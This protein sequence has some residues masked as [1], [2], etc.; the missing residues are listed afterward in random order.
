MSQL[1][2]ATH[3]LSRRSLLTSAGAL[4]LSAVA[5]PGCSEKH[6]SEPA[7]QP[8]GGAPRRGG[9]LTFA[10]NV[11]T[12]N[13][14]LDP[15]LASGPSGYLRNVSVFDTLTATNADGWR[16][17]PRL[18][19]LWEP[20]ADLTQWHF[21]LRPGVTFHDGRPLEAKDVVWT[22]RRI[23]DKELGSGRFSRFARTMT[24][25]GLSAPDKSTVV[26]KLTRPDSQLPYAFADPETVIVRDGQANFDPASYFGTGPYKLVSWTPGESLEMERNPDYWAGELPYLDGIRRVD[27][28]EAATATQGVLSGNYD[29]AE[30][31]SYA[32]AAQ[33]GQSPNAQLIRLPATTSL[34]L[35]MDTT[36]P[37]FTDPNV[38]KA[39]KL[40]V[41]RQAVLNT[42]YA[43]FGAMTGDLMLAPDDVYYPDGLGTGTYDPDQAKSLL[44]T[45]GFP[46]GLDIDLQAY[47]TY[48]PLAVAFADTAKAAGIRVKVQQGNP[49][50]YWDV[51]YL[52]EKFYTSDWQQFFPPDLLWYCYGSDATYN[53]SK[54]KIPRIDE[55][56][57]KILATTDTTQQKAFVKEGLGLAAQ[58]MGHIIP[59]MA[60]QLL[61]AKKNVQGVASAPANRYDL[62]RVYLSA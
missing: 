2:V 46:D 5:L 43:G 54:L 8:A 15:Q 48:S 41:D 36:Q 56:Y 30:A 53:E 55:L 32:A 47:G 29:I 7:S 14:K 12:V 35:V 4:A 50:T 37:P 62:R 10:A 13:E 33:L 23:L 31:V 19:E 45:A 39:F 25:D 24:P 42:V 11:S 58:N 3:P 40:A 18:A 1:S 34:V 44:A 52:V 49:D 16:L 9:V 59:V 60:D 57:N 61:L 22:F 6:A 17:E 26:I 21:T 28:P 20:N 51:V 38:R 27:A